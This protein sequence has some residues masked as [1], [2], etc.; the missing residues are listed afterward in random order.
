M[1]TDKSKADEFA[2]RKRVNLY[3]KVIITIII[4]LLIIPLILSIYL[5]FKVNKIEE[6]LNELVIQKNN[7]YVSAQANNQEIELE[8]P[9]MKKVYLTFDDGPSENTDE[10]LAILDE[11]NVKATFFVNGKTDE[12]SL[13][14]YKDIVKAGHILGLHSYTHEYDKV[15]GSVESFANEFNRLRELLYNTTG[16]EVNLIRFPGGSS[17]TRTGSVP[18]E[19]FI[20]YTNEIGFTYFDWNVS[21][22]DGSNVV[23]EADQIVNNVISKVDS[24]ETPVVL[25]HDTGFK[26]TTVDALPKIIEAL[27]HKGYQPSVIDDKVE[28]VQHIKAENIK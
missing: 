7:S 10:I 22:G 15:Y 18:I 13:E 26:T 19:D 21:S 5:M 9:V 27:I 6:I 25:M 8:V 4:I 20:R 16:Q 2:R 3:K 14:R 17:T 11:F 1:D 24:V 23:L 12:E 28:S